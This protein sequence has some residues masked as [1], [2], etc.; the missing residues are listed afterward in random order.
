MKKIIAFLGLIIL[1]VSCKNETETLTIYTA[2][3]YFPLEIG[4]YITYK[5]DSTVYTRLGT[6]KE[7][8]S[9]ELKLEN[10]Q[11][12]KDNNNRE[13]MRITAY[14]RRDA[15]AAWQPINTFMA[16][17]TGNGIEWV[18]NNMRFIKLKSPVREA[19]SWK[20]N[21]YLETGSANSQIGY[22]AEWDYT[23]GDVHMAKTIGGFQMDSTITVK[24]A[25][26]SIGNLADPKIYSEVNKSYE[27]YA[28]GIGLVYKYFEHTVF[29]PT[30]NPAYEDGSFTLELTMIDH[31]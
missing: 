10:T 28:K 23:Y 4:K 18:E 6:R 31:N 20:G 11:I 21:A 12:I 9:Y 27:I 1:L 7:I 13:A 29:Q 16:L 2:S 19:F 3:D 26:E 14:L 15:A 24:H 8:H 30:P 25:D 22:M 17:N 5:L